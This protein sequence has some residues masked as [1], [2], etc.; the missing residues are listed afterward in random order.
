MNKTVKPLFKYIGGKSWLRESLRDHL[1]E[2]LEEQSFE[3]YC[4]PFAGGLGSFLSIYDLLL[5]NGVKKVILSDINSNL[6]KTYQLI[7]SNPKDLINEYLSLE[8][9]FVARVPKN[10]SLTKDKN[11]LKVILTEAQEYFN[12]VKKEFNE[13]KFN[14]ST[15][16]S[17]RLI[18]LQK[19]AFNGVY[20]ENAKGQYN[21]PFNWSGS[22]MIHLIE[23]KVLELND[24]FVKLDI[25]FKEQSFEDMDYSLNAIYYLDP[26]YINEEISEN[27][28]NKNIF[29]LE[30]QILLLN[31]IKDTNF[32]YSNHK[33]EIL[34]KAFESFENI[35][36]Q[37][38]MRKNIMSS[39]SKTRKQ[40]KTEI[41]VRSVK[42]I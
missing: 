29:D 18:F 20:R 9:E 39:S 7:K 31:K 11:E 1:K 10:W 13:N 19:H 35:D 21:T 26:P 3:A 22:N 40:D 41:L 2:A 8:K 5:E 4:E 23:S 24:I 30:S 25:D 16:Q 42:R 14:L 27:K 12:F 38:I 6:I 37:E 34:L 36:V 17:A 15:K 32:I 28:Y 33:A